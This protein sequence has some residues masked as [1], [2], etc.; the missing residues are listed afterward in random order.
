MKLKDD[1]HYEFSTSD[2]ILIRSLLYAMKSI[3]PQR[4]SVF[5][6]EISELKN[7]SNFWDE[8]K[9]KVSADATPSNKVTVKS[10]KRSSRA[11]K[12]K[13]GL[14]LCGCHYLCHHA[15]CLPIKKRN[16]MRIPSL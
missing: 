9:D 5:T 6:R 16:I 15:E 12:R 3:L 8:D 4:V 10:I 7:M 2:A 11:L 14:C 13:G 1:L